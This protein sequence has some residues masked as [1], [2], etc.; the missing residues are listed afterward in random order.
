MMLSKRK[1]YNPTTAASGNTSWYNYNPL[2][3]V[4]FGANINF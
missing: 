3:T 4:T 1:G 2:S